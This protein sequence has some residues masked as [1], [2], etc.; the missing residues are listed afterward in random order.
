M[1]FF[2]ICSVFP[3]RTIL[4]KHSTEVIRSNEN[5]YWGSSDEAES[6]GKTEKKNTIIKSKDWWKILKTFTNPL[7]N[8]SIPPLKHN[9]EI[10]TEQIGKD[11]LLNKYFKE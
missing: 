5:S 6:G 2:Y 8:S 3:L 11:N 10:L 7:Q 4:R 9:D 1:I